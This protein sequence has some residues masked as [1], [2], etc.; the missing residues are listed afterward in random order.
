MVPGN[1]VAFTGLK[2]IKVRLGLSGLEL[3]PSRLVS[4]LVQLLT[5]VKVAR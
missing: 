4:V 1:P 2:S 5:G 3:A